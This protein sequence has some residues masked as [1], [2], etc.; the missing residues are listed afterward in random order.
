MNWKIALRQSIRD[1]EVPDLYSVPALPTR[2][3]SNAITQADVPILLTGD[4][5]ETSLL[6][7]Y[8]AKMLDLKILDITEIPIGE[9]SSS[10]HIE[11]SMNQC[12]I[13]MR[14]V[15]KYKIETYK[16]FLRNRTGKIRFV[17]TSSDPS[18]Q[19]DFSEE[20][21]NNCKMI[22]VEGIQVRNAE[23]KL[24]IVASLAKAY[25]GFD[26]KLEDETFQCVA[27]KFKNHG[28]NFIHNA[29]KSSCA[30]KVKSKIR[31][32]QTF[33]EKI[34]LKPRKYLHLSQLEILSKKLDKVL[35]KH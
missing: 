7:H 14:N 34:R 29:M 10:T 1:P 20:I 27:D 2:Q 19:G 4:H 13:L 15:N 6:V 12:I 5:H 25:H 3:L 32:N 11:L 8:V 22:K 24:K 21:Q 16:N 31:V 26:P 18:D 17:M 30:I 23:T 9:F 33:W 28:A 35:K